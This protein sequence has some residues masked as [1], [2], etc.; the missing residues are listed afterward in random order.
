MYE[1]RTDEL[2]DAQLADLPEGKTA[3]Y[4]EVRAM[5]EVA[6]WSGDSMR[7][8]NPDANVYSVPFGPDAEGTVIYLIQENERLVKVLEVIWLD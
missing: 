8:S 2:V 6:P 3:A 7:P 4:L 5:L 1:V